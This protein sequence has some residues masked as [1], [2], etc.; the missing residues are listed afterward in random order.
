MTEQQSKEMILGPCLVVTTEL[1]RGGCKECGG[2]C[3]GPDCGLHAAGC[4]YG[5]FGY[6]YWIYDP[7]C[8]LDHGEDQREASDAMGL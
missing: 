3:D 4:I 1:T 8:P 6:G 2:Q 5:G 7:D